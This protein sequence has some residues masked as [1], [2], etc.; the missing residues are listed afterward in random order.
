M[1]NYSKTP[2]SARYAFTFWAFPREDWVKNLNDY[3]DFADQYFAEH[4]FRCN[5]PLGSYFIRQDTS[6]LLS[7][8]HDG[9]IIS[10]DPIHAPGD[11]DQ[12]AW[13]DFLREFNEWAHPRERHPAAEPEPVRH[14]AACGRRLRRSLEDAVRL[15]PNRR[16]RRAD[17]QSVFRGADGVRP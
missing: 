5:M 15:G 16:P 6:S 17:G 10:L 13:A 8:T 1:I 3:V 9:D 12:A 14:Q 11:R 7:Y 2:K 4:G